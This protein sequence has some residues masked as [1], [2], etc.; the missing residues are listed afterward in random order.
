MTDCISDIFLSKIHAEDHLGPEAID[1]F[2]HHSSGAKRTHHHISRYC[3][4]RGGR[5]WEVHHPEEIKL[6]FQT[7]LVAAGVR[8]KNKNFQLVQKCILK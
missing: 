1:S 8:N 5:E 4:H 6:D 2:S 7:T 3:G